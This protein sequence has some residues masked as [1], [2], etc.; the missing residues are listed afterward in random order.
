MLKLSKIAKN[1]PDRATMRPL[2][3]S[4][5]REFWGHG[6]TERWAFNLFYVAQI[7]C[8]IWRD[9]QIACNT[10]DWSFI[11]QSMTVHSKQTT[12]IKQHI[13]QLGEKKQ[14]ESQCKLSIQMEIFL[15]FSAQTSASRTCNLASVF[16][17]IL[18][19]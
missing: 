16:Y 6:W 1:K 19:F 15:K 12:H 2:V 4:E 13:K 9:Q 17:W 11:C 7:I 14:W 5:Q 3:S 18:E 10:Y 8:S